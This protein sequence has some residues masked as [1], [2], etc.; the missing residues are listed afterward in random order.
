M[1]AR[2]FLNYWLRRY[3]ESFQ[4]GA[5][6][7]R[8]VFFQPPGG[9]LRWL[10]TQT[11]LDALPRPLWAA[12]VAHTVNLPQNTTL[13]WRGATYRV[14]RTVEFRLNDAPVYRLVLLQPVGA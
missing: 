11:E 8:G 2:A 4:V 14:V 12:A 1:I 3:G 5:Q 9:L 6:T 13:L 10:F 7:H